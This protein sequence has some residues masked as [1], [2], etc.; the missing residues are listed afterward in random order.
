M[1]QSLKITKKHVLLTNL[2]NKNISCFERHVQKLSMPLTEGFIKT[3]HFIKNKLFYHQDLKQIW[4]F[5]H[6]L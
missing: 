2:E 5:F 4:E 3:E 1:I 6:Y